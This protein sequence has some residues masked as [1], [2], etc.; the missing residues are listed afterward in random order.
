MDEPIKK[1]LTNSDAEFIAQKNINGSMANIL[2]R[3]SNNVFSEF[4]PE[5]LVK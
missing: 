2:H 4:L 1:R 3:Q 5:I